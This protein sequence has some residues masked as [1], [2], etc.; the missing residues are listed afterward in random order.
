MDPFIIC[1]EFYIRDNLTNLFDNC[2]ENVGLLGL[3]HIGSRRVVQMSCGFMILCS[4]FGT[5]Y[6]ISVLVWRVP[7]HFNVTYVIN[8]FSM[9]ISGKFGAF[10]A[11]IPLPIFAAIYCVLFGIVGRCCRHYINIKLL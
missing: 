6:Y 9:S 4:I 11:S 10:F 1:L 8:D 7:L 3:T 2:S 5:I